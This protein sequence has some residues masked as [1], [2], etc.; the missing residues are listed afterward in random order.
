M[1]A[2]SSLMCLQYHMN[3]LISSAIELKRHH[4]DEEEDKVV[5]PAPMDVDPKIDEKE[6]QPRQSPDNVSDS[7][8]PEVGDDENRQEANEHVDAGPSQSVEDGPAASE[9]A[10]S[11]EPNAYASP[12]NRESEKITLSLADLE[13]FFTISPHIHP[14]AGSATYRLRNGLARAVEEQERLAEEWMR[15]RNA[16]MEDELAGH[17]TFV[18]AGIPDA[19]NRSAVASS[20]AATSQP[21][22]R[23][24]TPSSIYRK[25]APSVLPNIP[26]IEI[27]TAESGG[28]KSGVLANLAVQA[29]PYSPNTPRAPTIGE[30]GIA[31]SRNTRSA[32]ASNPTEAFRVE[33]EARGILK[34]MDRAA[35]SHG[36][37]ANAHVHENGADGYELAERQLH[38]HHWN[39][40]DP[41]VIL[42]DILG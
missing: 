5:P 19:S 22:T 10:R 29:V 38:G 12:A 17:T 13:D 23:G 30:G 27:S 31:I 2:D 16:E 28:A 9:S 41:A 25:G 33:L 21:V 6:M 36:G 18:L 24:G 1:I 8:Q 4:A 32:L 15:R 11:V 26:K 39:Y 3:D 35:G 34:S 20:S 14:H 42:K 37:I 40:V 7:L